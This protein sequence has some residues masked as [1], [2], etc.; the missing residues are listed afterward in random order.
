V[1][2]REWV[3]E[4]MIQAMGK[5]LDRELELDVAIALGILGEK[6]ERFA[7][8]LERIFNR[9]ID[10][11]DGLAL[12]YGLVVA[13]VDPKKRD[14]VLK[15]LLTN[16]DR[17]GDCHHGWFVITGVSNT[18]VL[19]APLS[20][21]I[22]KLCKDKDER[23]AGFAYG[24]LAAAGLSVRE[25]TPELIRFIRGSANEESRAAAAYALTDI[26]DY[27]H[28]P[29]LE[30]ALKKESSAKVRKNLGASITYIKTFE[31]V[32]WYGPPEW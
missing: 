30:E 31:P 5:W 12:A 21:E 26:A 11:G 15:R 7:G 23:I 14:A 18:Y 1:R 2:A 13:N 28:L 32:T 27:S 29:Q 3:S 8:K 25:V 22:V 6:A 17:I 19:V 10:A 4:A 20:K 16:F 24:L 9:K